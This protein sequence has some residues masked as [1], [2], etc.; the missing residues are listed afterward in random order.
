M[1]NWVRSN[2]VRMAFLLLP[3]LAAMQ[4]F[5]SAACS[6][7]PAGICAILGEVG[8]RGALDSQDV[9]TASLVAADPCG[10]HCAISLPSTMPSFGVAAPDSWVSPI[11]FD[12][13]GGF[14]EPPHRPPRP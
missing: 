13:A 6:E 14:P 8:F 1:A 2:A 12:Y 4:V 3:L 11:T 5:T 10:H 9:G 7:A